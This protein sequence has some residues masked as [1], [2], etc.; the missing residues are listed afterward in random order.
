[1]MLAMCTAVYHDV[2][3]LPCSLDNL[4]SMPLLYKSCL[5]ELASFCQT[6]NASTLQFCANK[7]DH[8][9][10]FVVLFEIIIYRASCGRPVV[11]SSPSC[12]TNY[13]DNAPRSPD[14]QSILNSLFFHGIVSSYPAA[15]HM[16][17]HNNYY[18]IAYNNK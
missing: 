5:E 4:H 1:M 13:V 18:A 9:C 6:Q 14:C 3:I 11:L 12:N 16:N 2:A 10:H 15:K 8:D 17:L 7:S